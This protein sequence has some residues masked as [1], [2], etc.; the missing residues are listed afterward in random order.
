[1]KKRLRLVAFTLAEVL[2]VL[3]IIGV[4]AEMTI[5]D[6]I[7]NSQKQV[8]V[9]S[10]KKAYTNVNQVLTLISVD[11]GCPDDLQCTGLFAAS[12]TDQSLGDE[13][14]KYFKV[15][16]N[17][18]IETKKGCFPVST[19]LNYDGSSADS[20]Q[21][22]SWESYKF[23]TADGMS[24]DITNDKDNCEKNWS[25]SGTGNASQVCGTVYIDINGLKGPNYYGKDTFLFYITN[26]RGALLYP[27][28]GSDEN[29]G[30]YA[31][32]GWNANNANNCSPSGSKSGEFCPGRIME[33]DW[34]IDY[35]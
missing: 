33:K 12:T 21:I 14:V 6:L 18:G 7:Q 13:L 19:N 5:P 3:G 35:Y 25:I 26:G 2:I 32:H 8:Y 23:V 1:M 34:E 31:N 29:S 20:L 15:I 24:F 22:D 27:S 17:C 28:G 30:I 11:K 10:L 4:V 16:K 9:T